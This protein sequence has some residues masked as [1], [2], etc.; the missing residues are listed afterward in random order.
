MIEQRGLVG[1]HLVQAPIQRILFHQR[2]VRAEQI[3]HCA[4]L[5]PQPVQAPLAPG[6]DQAVT[7][8]R[9][10]DV[11]PTGAFATIGQARFPEPIK[12]QSLVQ[13]AGEPTRA[14]LPR[15][16]QLHRL[17]AHLDA[18][19]LGVFGHLTVGGK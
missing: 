14:P 15:P 19:T 11:P 7:D 12:L 4:L 6:V 2:I 1:E 10:K 9:L 5:K 8:K 18:I 16:M 13:L 3:S 17:Q